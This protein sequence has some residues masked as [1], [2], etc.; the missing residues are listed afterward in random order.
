MGRPEDQVDEEVRRAGTVALLGRPNV[1]KSTLLNALLGTRIAIVSHHPQTTRDRIAGILTLRGVQYVLLDTPGFHA[2]KTRLGERM[3]DLATG[4][5]SD[6]DVAVFV[7]DLS[8]DPAI[9]LR[10]KALLDTLPA[11]TPVVLVV[12]KID[13]LANK[14]DLLPILQA[15]G[16]LR[17]FDAVVPVSAKTRGGMDRILL[18][19]GKLLPEG[20]ALYDPEEL[21]DKP[22]RFFVAEFVREQIL[23]RTRQEVPHGIAVSV[24]SFDEGKKLA[25]ILVTVHVSKESHKG[26]VIGDGGKMLREV[27]TAARIRAEKLLGQKVHLETVVRASPGWLD[28]PKRLEELGYEGSAKP[29]AKRPAK[30]VKKKTAKRKS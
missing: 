18:E 8:R 21:S 17:N 7:T 19:V 6:C 25:R 10:D 27:G 2:A 14:A 12:N 11:K 3:N 15:Y 4:A 29:K 22:T 20:P 9:R 23:R 26:I 1:G 30:A 28:D 5:A 16:E 13:R 24:E